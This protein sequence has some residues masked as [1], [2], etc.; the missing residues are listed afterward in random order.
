MRVSSNNKKKY[1]CQKC[2]N[3]IPVDDLEEI[4][5]GELERFF[6]STDEIEAAHPYWRDD[7]TVLGGIDMWCTTLFGGWSPFGT[8]KHEKATPEQEKADVKLVVFQEKIQLE[9]SSFPSQ[10]PKQLELIHRI[11]DPFDKTTITKENV[12]FVLGDSCLVI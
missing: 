5:R 9:E 1:V 8:M 6:V 12:A 2:R 3:K 11:L 10:D 4:Y 7:G